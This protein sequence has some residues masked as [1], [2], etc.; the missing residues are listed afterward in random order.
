MPT[1]ARHLLFLPP[2]G[3]RR[4]HGCSR[5]G[6]QGSSQP[7]HQWRLE[8]TWDRLHSAPRETLPTMSRSLSP[9][10]HLTEPLCSLLSCCPRPSASAEVTALVGRKPV[11]AAHPTAQAVGGC[12]TLPPHQASREGSL[13]IL[14]TL[15]PAF[16]AP[17]HTQ[18][19]I[20]LQVERL[21]S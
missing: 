7:H 13:S 14:L 1:S 5:N 6:S 3:S 2:K 9:H 12:K 21:S 10:P 4:L 11:S 17:W 16:P 19:I 18:K 20:I 8:V 15:A